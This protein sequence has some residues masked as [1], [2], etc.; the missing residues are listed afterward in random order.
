MPMI[1]KYRV[2]GCNDLVPPAAILLERWCADSGRRLSSKFQ[3]SGEGW[4][5]GLIGDHTSVLVLNRW[6]AEEEGIRTELNNWAAAVESWDGNAN[7]WPLM[8]RIIQTK[9][10]FL[11]T[12][13]GEGLDAER[14]PLQLTRLL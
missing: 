8:E 10:L 4:F 3:P 1:I 12:Q 6:L 13:Q 2:F 5:H 9:Q 14:W 11:L 7:V